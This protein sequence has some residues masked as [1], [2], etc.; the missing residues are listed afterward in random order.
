MTTTEIKTE[1]KKAIDFYLDKTY[2]IEDV[3]NHIL[4]II[5]E[6]S[7]TGSKHIV[8]LEC[9][10]FK[11]RELRETQRI[12]WAGHK[13]KLPLCKAQ[14][15]AIDKRIQHLLAAGGYSIDRYKTNAKQNTLFR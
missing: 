13:S 3:Q 10:V 4:R 7:D 15:T 8:Q 12:F 1:V 6:N 14:E 9:L 11:I 5:R 2:D